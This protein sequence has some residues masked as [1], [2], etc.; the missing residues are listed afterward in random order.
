MK[1]KVIAAHCEPH[2]SKVCFRR[3]FFQA[4]FTFLPHNDLVL[5]QIYIKVIFFKV[6]LQDLS[7]DDKINSNKKGFPKI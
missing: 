5:G 1:Y 4:K 6:K 3:Q 2:R 7:I